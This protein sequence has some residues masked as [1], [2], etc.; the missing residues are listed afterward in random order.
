MDT[1]TDEELLQA[2]NE[3]NKALDSLSSSP[4]TDGPFTEH[5]IRRREIVLLR[6]VTAY[7]IQDAREQNQK[8]LEAL[9]TDIYRSMTD[10]LETY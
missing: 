9:N 4:K 2:I 8:L 1:M 7:K 10:F 3:A 6:Q 5:E